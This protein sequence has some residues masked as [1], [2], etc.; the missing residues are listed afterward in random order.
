MDNQR[1]YENILNSLSEIEG[2]RIIFPIHPR[3]LGKIKQFSLLESIQS[4]EK[5]EL[6]E[7]LGYLDFLKLESLSYIIVTDSVEKKQIY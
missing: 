4:K 3:T 2:C 6:I 1:K 5:I 7:P